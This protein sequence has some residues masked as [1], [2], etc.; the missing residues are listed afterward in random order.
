MRSIRDPRASQAHE[1]LEVA[2]MSL[3]TPQTTQMEKMV[4]ERVVHVK[5]DREIKR[6]LSKF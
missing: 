1:N 3:K 5:D 2:G 4:V 6:L